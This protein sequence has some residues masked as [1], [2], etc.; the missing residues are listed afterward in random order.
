MTLDDSVSA[1]TQDYFLQEAA[2]LLQ[3][4]D[5]ELQDLTQSFSVQKVHNL[6]RAAHTLKGAAASVGLDGVKEVTHS[7][8]DVFKALC[9]QDT[10]ITGEIEGL[11]FA[12]YDCLKLLMSAHLSGAQ[13]DEADVAKQMRGVVA[14]LRERLGDRFGQ[15][16]HLPTS[17]ELGFDMTQSIFEVGVMQRLDLFEAALVDPD[18]EALLALMQTQAEVFMGLAESLDLP[19]F[20][21]IAQTTQ[22][23]LAQNLHSVLDIAP[24]ALANYRAA[25]A[26]VLGGDRTV[27]G[28]LS[29]ALEQFTKPV[30]G[31]SNYP[32][33]TPLFELIEESDRYELDNRQPTA[34]A[35]ANIENNWLL[36]LL[37]PP[38]CSTEEEDKPPLSDLVPDQL[39]MLDLPDDST[40]QFTEEEIAA[41]FS[42][43][44]AFLTSAEFD[45]AELCELI[46]DSLYEVNLLPEPQDSE[47]QNAESPDAESLDEELSSIEDLDVEASNVTAQSHVRLGTKLSFF[48]SSNIESSNTNLTDI[49]ISEVESSEI[50]ISDADVTEANSSENNHSTTN[51]FPDEWLNI[52]LP[53]PEFSALYPPAN[54]DPSAEKPSDKLSDEPSDIALSD[55]ALPNTDFS[56]LEFSTV[57]FSTLDFPAIDL[58]DIT[59]ENNSSEAEALPDLSLVFKLDDIL[60]DIC[61]PPPSISTDPNALSKPKSQRLP[62]DPKASAP[63]KTKAVASVPIKNHSSQATLRI[64]VEHLDQ[65]TQVMG[66]LLTQQN[67]Q[68]LYNE[69]LVL[70]VKQLLGR[71]AQQ[72]KQL[73]QPHNITESALLT[74]QSRLPTRIPELARSLSQFDPLELQQY[75][76]IQLLAQAFSESSAQQTESAEAIELFLRR[77]GQTLIKQRRLLASVRETLLDVRM[78]PLDKVFKRFPSAIKRLEAQYPKQIELAILGG[79]VLVDRVIADKLYDPLLHLLR[80]AFD[81]GIETAEQRQQQN[82]LATGTITIE[83][84]QQGC[85]LVINVKDDGQGLDLAKIRRKAIDSKLITEN[86]AATLTSEQTTDL[87]FEPGFSTASEISHLSGRGVGLDAVRAQVRSLQGWVT[88]S[89]QPK[90]GTCF[91]LQIPSSLTIAK[92]MLCES[93]NRTYA[94]IADAIEHILIPSA[95]QVRTWEGGKAITWQTNEK[96]HLI[97]VSAL[98][99]VLHYASPIPKHQSAASQDSAKTAIANPVIL[100]R[101]ENSLIGIEVDRLLGEQ[102]LAISAL[103]AAIV[104]PT[105]LYGSSVL[106][107][108]QLTLVLDSVEIAKIALGKKKKRQKPK[109][110]DEPNKTTIWQ[111]VPKTA[112]EVRQKLALT[113][114]D[115]ITVR[116]SLADALQKA[117]YQVIQAKNGTE[118]LQQLLRYPNVDVILCDVEMPGMNGFEFLTARRQIPEIAAIPTIMLTSRDGSKHRLLAKEL[119]ALSYLTKP[120]LAPQML[121]TVA[122]AIKTTAHQ[123]VTH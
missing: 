114:D 33:L 83:A 88:V 26:D 50:E 119:G 58:S 101:H 7:L 60:D 2:E 52:E 28:T 3:T 72:Q 76:D 9:H 11:I 69:Q 20:A 27:G 47:L 43:A 12:A 42:D 71:I 59:T 79:D 21:A 35:T 122:A 10:L 80:N 24:V 95:E 25:Q 92:L 106:P 102:E 68:S 121:K 110:F 93:Q 15:D 1:Q 98:A 77:S 38:V 74:Q 73:D 36:R 78:L 118:G 29:T 104:P 19:G 63:I 82:K 123:T 65:I 120:F 37:K 57:D 14:Q 87:L 108:G 39:A 8:E 34:P 81:H 96:E 22:T 17:A 115:S 44:I 49:E 5:E 91:T 53:T 99:N 66:K 111:E 113:I 112:I 23:A 107:D 67:K 84:S 54:G 48:E 51:Y 16:G 85:H 61:Q 94:L 86:E 4:M 109:Q 103:D 41:T 89:H 18:P 46:P 6:M 30:P 70:L 56:T 90:A 31:Q 97:P 13:I 45:E 105:Y 64:A 62:S 40:E 32:V 100:I 55:I 116:N 117:G 75:S